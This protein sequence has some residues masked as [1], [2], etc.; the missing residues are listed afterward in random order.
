MS[1][2]S[3]V[4]TQLNGFKY[5]KWLNSA[6]WP[7]DGT[8]TGTNAPGQSGLVQTSEYWNINIRLQC[9]KVFNYVQIE[10]WMLDNNTW[11]HLTV[12]K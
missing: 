2:N 7:I 4:C 12:C 5:S 3:F 9:L 8:L 6:I 10:L 11:N 1:Q